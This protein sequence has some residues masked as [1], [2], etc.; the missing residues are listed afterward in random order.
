MAEENANVT[1]GAELWREGSCT[2]VPACG[3]DEQSMFA[4]ISSLPCCSFGCSAARRPS[5]CG[6]GKER[7]FGTAHHQKPATICHCCGLKPPSVYP[8]TNTHPP[9]VQ[10][11][12]KPTDQ[13]IQYLLFASRE[14]TRAP[15]STR[16]GS[17]GKQIKDENTTLPPVHERELSL[18][19][20]V[21][22][23]CKGSIVI[24]ES[25]W[26]RYVTREELN[27]C[28]IEGLERKHG[29]GLGFCRASKVKSSLTSVSWT[30]SCNVPLDLSEKIPANTQSL[31]SFMSPLSSWHMRPR[32]K[33]PYILLKKKN[34]FFWWWWCNW[35]F[36]GINCASRDLHV[37]NI[38][39]KVLPCICVT[40]AWIKGLG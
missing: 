36:S 19:P 21:W 10:K 2:C 33:K 8:H 23:G 7:G 38:P 25:E 40:E 6:A 31:W 13:Q 5:G 3:W 16:K 35:L 1:Q 26:M 18:H 28:I 17:A 12:M 22:S 20:T 11:Q 24:S 15:T 39:S 37:A 30:V 14:P 32:P 9:A 29:D 27:Q 4:H 34:F